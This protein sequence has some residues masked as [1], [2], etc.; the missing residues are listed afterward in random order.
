M[1]FVAVRENRWARVFMSTWKIVELRL[2]A[3]ASL[4]ARKCRRGV[5]LAGGVNGCYSVV[6]SVLLSVMEDLYLEMSRL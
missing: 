4:L 5:K 3:S 1:V 2:S 6:S